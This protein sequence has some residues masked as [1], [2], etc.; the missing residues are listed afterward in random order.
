MIE[1]T[2]I[3][4]PV[5]A[6]IARFSL[7]P[8]NDS[9]LDDRRYWREKFGEILMEVE[10]DDGHVFIVKLYPYDKWKDRN[11]IYDDR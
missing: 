10:C 2:E 8:E 6:D 9:C 7:R 3:P 4:Y 5:M 1:M 11:K